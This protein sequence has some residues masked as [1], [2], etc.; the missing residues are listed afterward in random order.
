MH[1]MLGQHTRMQK[2]NVCFAFCLILCGFQQEFSVHLSNFSGIL[3]FK[4]IG[5]IVNLKF[6]VPGESKF[7]KKLRNGVFRTSRCGL[8]KISMKNIDFSQNYSV[9]KF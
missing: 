5:D 7:L 9:L 8:K 4:I 6:L 3:T 2:N 1:F